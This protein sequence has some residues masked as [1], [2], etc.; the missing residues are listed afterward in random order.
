L[1]NAVQRSRSAPNDEVQE[2]WS[3]STDRVL[4]PRPAG[5]P[6]RSMVPMVAGG[7]AAAVIAGLLVWFVQRPAADAPRPV[8]NSVAASAASAAAA[9]ASPSLP[10]PVLVE[11]ASQA[12]ASAS[13]AVTPSLA[14]P[15]SAPAPVQA[16][17]AA[18]SAAP[19]VAK[20]PAA[21]PAN[22]R[23]QSSTNT[24]AAQVPATGPA[25]MTVDSAA[26]RPLPPSA[27]AGASSAQRTSPN[28]GKTTTAVNERRAPVL[29]GPAPIESPV[30]RA[31]VESSPRSQA[32][33]AERAND[34]ALTAVPSVG[35]DPREQCGGRM[36]LALH[37]CL[38]RECAKPQY[39]DHGECQQVRAIEERARIRSSP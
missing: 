10:V 24:V 27:T 23:S 15:T 12:A 1:P 19:V 34:G 16:T 26:L 30:Q 4:P 33:A 3:A 22:A 21:A 39:Y 8:Q 6:T 28:S 36:L 38:V 13:Q 32:N 31:P 35:R 2:T 20:T 11:A 5:L 9:A 18:S 37:K 7:A 25:G 17:V 29:P 14:G